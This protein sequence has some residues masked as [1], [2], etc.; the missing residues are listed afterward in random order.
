MLSELKKEKYYFSNDLKE[1]LRSL[2]FVKAYLQA[3]FFN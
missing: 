3:F 2:L 1:K